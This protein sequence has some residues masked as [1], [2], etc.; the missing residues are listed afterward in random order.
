MSGESWQ[1]DERGDQ[2]AQ[3]EFSL[4]NYYNNLYLNTDIFIL[5]IFI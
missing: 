2:M 4:P 1:M 3:S 5:N